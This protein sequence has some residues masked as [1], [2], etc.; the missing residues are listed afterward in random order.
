MLIHQ[1]LCVDLPKHGVNPLNPGVDPPKPK[2]CDDPGPPNPGADPQKPS[3]DRPK[4]AID[5]Q[6]PCVGQP[7]PGVD[8]PNPGC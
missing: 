8:P 2:T 5:T 6:T 1:T 7:K 4:P 3:V